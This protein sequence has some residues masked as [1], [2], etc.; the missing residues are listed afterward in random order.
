MM[1]SRPSRTQEEVLRVMRQLPGCS[2]AQGE[3]LTEDGLFSM[4]IALQL[5]SGARVAV[6]VDGPTHYVTS[7]SGAVQLNGA[8][9]LRNRLLEARGWKV[10]SV[11]AKVW[12]RVNEGGKAA[13][14]AYLQKLIIGE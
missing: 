2:S 11:P 14:L 3:Q 9:Q 6:E 5:P 13:Q 4:D 8:T 1:Q 7:S 12:D 10:L